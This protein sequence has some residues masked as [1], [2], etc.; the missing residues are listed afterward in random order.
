MSAANIEFVQSLYAA[1]GRG[2]LEAIAAAMAPDIRW[3]IVGRPEDYPTF[4]ERVGPQAV[5]E[6]LGLVGQLHEVL[7]FAPETFHAD[8]D[9]VV[10]TGRETWRVRAS[11]R[12]VE[13]P[14]VQ[15]FTLCD[16]QVAAFREFTDTARFALADRG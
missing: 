4:G 10:V 3:E 6:F 1:F 16:G 7:A 8:G 13:A 2:D 15:I 9:T 5:L 14:W 12:E 11:G